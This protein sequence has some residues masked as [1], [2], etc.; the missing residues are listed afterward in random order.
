MSRGMANPLP[1]LR[2]LRPSLSVLDVRTALP[3]PKVVD[4]F[5]LSP[6]WRSLIAEI[7]S[8]RGPLCEDP[9]C[10]RPSRF[11]SRVY[12]D[13]IHELQDGGAPLDKSNILLRCGS[14]HTRK[15]LAVRAERQRG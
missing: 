5:Y 12:G 2:T 6:A 14:C 13:H 7:I 15:T 10:K 1:R 3:P 9:M 11:A 8:E 4:P